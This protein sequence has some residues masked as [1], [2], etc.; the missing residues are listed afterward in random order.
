MGIKTGAIQGRF[1]GLHLGHMEFLLE[2]KKRCDFLIIG[3]TNYDIHSEMITENAN[4]KRFQPASNPFTFYERMMMIRLS[5][6]DAGI[7]ESDFCITPFPIECPEKII[8]FV[9]K[10]AV[11][12]QTIYDEWGE[13]KVKTLESLGYQT[14]IMWIR[15]D[16]QRITSGTEI[17]N[18]IAGNKDWQ[19]LVPIA[20]V[21][22]ICETGLDKR[23]QILKA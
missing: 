21:T 6:R 3:I 18:L 19:H 7:R 20:A 12:F 11:F 5:M 15:E 8:N 10:D 23:L 16:S 9:P 4:M 1:Q 13:K 22:Y 17:R 14:E 2:A